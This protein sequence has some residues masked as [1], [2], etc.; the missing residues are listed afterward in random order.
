M[1]YEDITLRDL[2]YRENLRQKDLAEQLGVT[3]AS[4]S[5]WTNGRTPAA[6]RRNKMQELYPDYRIMWG[7]DNPHE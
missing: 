5:L 4:V 1:D 6:P 3:I 7:K 2:M